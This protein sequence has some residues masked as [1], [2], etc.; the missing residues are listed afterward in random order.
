MWKLTLM[1][2]RMSLIIVSFLLLSGCMSS[3][4]VMKFEMPEQPV[5]NPVVWP[6]PPEI[7]RYVYIG[8]LTG[9]QNFVDSD[10]ESRKGFDKVF[11]AIVGLDIF[12]PERVVLKRPQSVV[13]DQL[14]RIYV[15]DV[16][17][18]AVFVFD[19]Q[20]GTLDVWEWA[21]KGTNF[22][23][24]IG[25]VLGEKNE[26]FIT[27]AQLKKI[28]VLD[29]NTGEPIR[30]FGHK[31][32]KRPT[33]LARD[34]LTGHLYVSDT[35]GQNI[36]MFNNKGELLDVIGKRGIEPGQFNYPTYLSFNNNQLYVSD[37][38]NARIQ[39]LT[40]DGSAIKS[41]GKRGVFIGNFMRPKGV[42][43]DSDGNVYAIES[44]YDHLLIFN[45]KGDFLLP[46]GGAGKYSGRFF[47]PAGVWID[48][49]NRVYIADMLNGR[50]AVFQYLGNS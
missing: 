29:R 11:A 25:I 50:V 49:K 39:V 45:S 32:L 9:E 22:Y 46:I 23:N 33:G 2:H 41:I 27:D 20:T 28:Y 38:M 35:Q 43:A 26:I 13:T 14:G 30:Q 21:E 5:S 44:Y 36:K 16:G 34:P 42:A 17:R 47:L 37:T 18:Q 1:S 10:G 31:L 12:Q 48:Q 40:P 8:E 15:T 4:R 24:P 19:G 6:E 3:H 7:A